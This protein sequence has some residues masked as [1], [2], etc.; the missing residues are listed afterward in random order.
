MTHNRTIGIQANEGKSPSKGL[1]LFLFFVSGLA[2]RLTF[3]GSKSLWLDEANSLRVAEMGQAALWSGS[4]E[5]YHPPLFY[6]LLELWMQLGKSEFFLR[7]P[8]AVLGS[9][10]VPLAYLLGKDLLGKPTGLSVA[11]LV[12]FSPLLVWYSQELRP[13]ALLCV[14]GLL[15]MVATAKFFLRPNPG[16]WLLFIF[17][18]AATLY[19][20]YVAIVMLFLQI[21]LF[22]LLQAAGRTRGYTFFFWLAG[23][24]IV[25]AAYWP[26]LQTPAASTFLR[27]SV[28][29]QDYI[30]Q[31][32]LE[33]LHIKLELASFSPVYLLFFI[34]LSVIFFSLLYILFRWTYRRGF[35]SALQKSPW[36]QVVLVP[37]FVALLLASV[38]PRGYSIKR[39]LVL[40][41][42]YILLIFAWFWPWKKG[43]KALLLTILGLSFISSFVCI[44]LI[45]KDQ[46]R[47]T[48][49]YI[50]EHQENG[51]LVI[52]EPTYMTIP[53]DYYA[54]GGV[55]RE[56]LPFGA[57]PALLE[58][59]LSVHPRIWFVTHQ[60]DGDAQKRTQEW[61]DEY[62]I[63]QDAQDFYRLQVQLFTKKAP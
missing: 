5:I 1:I 46:W 28:Q 27:I 53:F 32:L 10:G 55:D 44:S 40:L 30:S 33:R 21:I 2:L 54:A 57:D 31:L 58:N 45:P 16:W 13:Y 42:P 51:D 26:W 9:L 35:Y 61:L 8:G 18:M 11:G 25:A 47:E 41:W 20:H 60:Y 59:L 39:Q 3:L 15:A 43:S 62:A 23:W 24:V 19:L 56:G 36:I 38:I 48:T 63:L 6:W 4:W 14:F 22:I 49:A 17:G 52:L 50:R 12:A 7:L 29:N 37:L 34:V